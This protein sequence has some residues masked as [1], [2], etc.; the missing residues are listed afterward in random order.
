MTFLIW[1][2]IVATLLLIYFHWKPKFELKLIQESDYDY[3][4]LYLYYLHKIAPEECEYRCIKLFSF[5]I[6]RKK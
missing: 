5:K 6:K 3:Y 1:Y 2:S 4:T